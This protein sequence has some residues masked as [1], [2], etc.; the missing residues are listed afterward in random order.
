MRSLALLSVGIL[1]GVLGARVLGQSAPGGYFVEQDVVVAAS[2][3]GPHA[4]G[5]QTVA[6]S[7]FKSVPNLK[8]VFRK[9]A[10]KP[11]AGI[12]YHQQTEDEIYYVLSGRGQMTLDGKAIDVGP[13]TAIL[14]RTGSSHGLKQLG[15]DD[16]VIL[17]N[18]EQAPRAPSPR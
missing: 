9:R 17:I 14:T 10:L 12:G 15:S 6:Y 11:G 16:L 8:L 1:I 5:G 2:E 13:G 7:F 3:P 18:Y 4:G